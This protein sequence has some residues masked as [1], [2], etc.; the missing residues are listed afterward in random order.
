ME[1]GK[2]IFEFP[3]PVKGL[4]MLASFLAGK[5]LVRVPKLRF[6]RKYSKQLRS[7]QKL[8]IFGGPNTFWSEKSV[9]R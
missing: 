1:N 7:P 3:S 5:L 8:Q 9:Q 6:S 2:C 4:N